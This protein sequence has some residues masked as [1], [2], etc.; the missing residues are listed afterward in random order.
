MHLLDH[1]ILIL[2]NIQQ[3][4]FFISIAIYSLYSGIIIYN[5]KSLR[6]TQDDTPKLRAYKSTRTSVRK[7]YKNV[8]APIGSTDCTR[9][10]TASVCNP[11]RSVVLVTR[12]ALGHL[13]GSLG[14]AAALSLQ[15]VLRIVG[16]IVR[17]V[18]L[19]GR[20]VADLGQGVAVEVVPGAARRP[21]AAVGGQRQEG[22]RRRAGGGRHEQRACVHGLGVPQADV[23][24]GA[25][26]AAEVREYWSDENKLHR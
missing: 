13:S 25:G 5:V 8:C 26:D 3:I 2:N 12:L 16:Q 6:R 20:V 15:Q 19:D 7:S 14:C 22:G 21:I 4:S 9:S 1:C 10:R 11:V 17:K 24:A 23:H 18:V